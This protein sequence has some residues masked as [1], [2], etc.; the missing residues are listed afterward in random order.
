MDHKRIRE[1][2]KEEGEAREKG[3]LGVNQ[4]RERVEDAVLQLDVELPGHVLA[5]VVEDF[6]LGGIDGQILVIEVVRNACA[7]YLVGGYGIKSISFT[8]RYDENLQADKQTLEIMD[9]NTGKV[10][11]KSKYA[12]KWNDDEHMFQVTVT[13][14]DLIGQWKDS[15]TPRIQ[16]RFEGTVSK[17]APAAHKVGNDWI[18][19]LNNGLTP[20]RPHGLKAP[21]SEPTPTQRRGPASGIAP[22]KRGLAVSRAGSQEHGR[23]TGRARI[24]P[25]PPS[26]RPQHAASRCPVQPD[27]GTRQS[28]PVTTAERNGTMNNQTQAQDP[29]NNP[30]LEGTLTPG[31][32]EPDTIPNSDPWRFGPDPWAGE[33]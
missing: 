25:F 10:I 27:N 11:P 26:R 21:T 7:P 31:T 22:R 8:D 17:D 24:R 32:D 20:N 13:D 16:L 5:L 29:W 18:L 33:D 19:T 4:A 6:D 2:K 3:D 14:A 12:T 23:R 1:W 28:G 9:L 15:G 30:Q